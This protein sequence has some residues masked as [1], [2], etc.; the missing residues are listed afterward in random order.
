MSERMPGPTLCLL[1]DLGF[2]PEAEMGASRKV[3]MDERG[4]ASLLLASLCDL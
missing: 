4:Q 1:L 2:P 3:F